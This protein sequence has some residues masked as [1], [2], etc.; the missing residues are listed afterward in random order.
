MSS[1]KRTCLKKRS[2]TPQLKK[3]KIMPLL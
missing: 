3:Y 2:L 1:I